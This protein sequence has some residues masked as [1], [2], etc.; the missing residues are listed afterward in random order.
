M[1][2]V[3]VLV[4]AAAS[5]TDALTEIEVHW[6]RAG[7]EKVVFN[8]AAS[9]TLAR[10]IREGAPADLLLSADE[11][12]M[13]TL[14]KAGLLVPGTRRS[15]LSNRLVVVVPADSPLRLSA[16]DDLVGAAVRKIAIAEPAIVPAGVYAKEYLV[17]I[18]LWSALSSKIVPT[19]N[20]RGA[21]AAVESGNVDAG[22]VYKT[23]AL[24]SK[25]V[26]TAFEVPPAEGPA[27]SYPFALVEGAPREAAARRF[28]EYLSSPTARQV[29]ARHGFILK[30]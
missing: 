24:I 18:G 30:D 12:Q 19:E 11:A 2:G 15:V 25:G 6:E 10:Q 3:L 17:R 29:F 9:S 22:I 28:L 7:G 26:R 14:E 4:F 1:S 21:L 16:A 20:V 5:L 13:D 23:D 27:I 8:F